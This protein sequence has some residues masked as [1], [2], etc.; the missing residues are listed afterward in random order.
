M[1]HMTHT[2]ARLLEP[3]RSD[4]CRYTGPRKPVK[5]PVQRYWPDQKLDKSPSKG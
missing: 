1:T 4:Q 3:S 5:R 2:S